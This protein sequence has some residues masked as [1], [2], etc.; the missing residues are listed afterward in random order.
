MEEVTSACASGEGGGGGGG[1]RGGGGRRGGGGGR[2]SN[3][4]EAK[5][6]TRVVLALV[7]VYNMHTC[8]YIHSHVFLH[9]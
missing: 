7:Q 5:I 2:I 8:T 1:G 3:P 4:T 9:S 6:I